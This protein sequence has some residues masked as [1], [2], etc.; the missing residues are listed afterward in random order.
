MLDLDHAIAR[1]Q[2]VIGEEL[3][4]GDDWPCRV[5]GSLEL[6]EPMG[7]RLARERYRE[8]GDEGG[9]VGDAAWILAEARVEDELL[10]AE[11]AAEPEPELLLAPS[12][13]NELSSLRKTWGRAPAW[14][15]PRRGGFLPSRRNRRLR[16]RRRRSLI[17]RARRRP[18]G[19]CR[20]LARGK[21]GEDAD[22]TE[23]AGGD[24]RDG[25]GEPE[26]RTVGLAVDR[27]Q[28]GYRLDHE[29]EAAA[30]AV[31]PALPEAGDGTVDEPWVE[32]C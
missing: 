8:K 28:A 24:V 26:R 11:Q 12:T 31:G 4:V 16:R 7:L 32:G 6:G 14:A 2:L 19:P 15:G 1:A 17:Y 21:C 23:E 13:V 3:G 29:I 18:A 10:A 20:S 27:D 25:D 22:R 9:V 30:P 5:A